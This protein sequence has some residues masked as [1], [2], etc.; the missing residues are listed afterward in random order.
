MTPTAM[1]ALGVLGVFLGLALALSI[2]G[3][4]TAERQAVGRSLAAI[5]AIQS[6]P[7]SMRRELD[8]PFIDRVVGPATD[9]LARFARRF[10]PA[11][12]ADRIRRRLD[13]AGNPPGWD[14]DRILAFRSLG[15]FSGAAIVAAIALIL[16][17]PLPQLIVL[18]IVAPLVGWFMPS[19]LLY[20]S[21]QKRSAQ[22]RRELPDALD[23]LTISVEAG[24]AFNA[25]LAEVARKTQ[26][27]VAEEFFR[28]LQE[29]QIGRGRSDAMRGLGER[30]DV[31]ELRGF[32]GAMVQADAFGIPISNVL[33][34]QSREMRV[35][36][37]QH[38]EEIAQRVPV[39][40]LFPLVFFIL[41]SLFIVILGPAVVQIYRNVLQGGL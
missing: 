4:L 3:G 31:P 5:Q 11:D 34:V 39:K 2:V 33:R 19:L 20:N 41:P 8:R 40:I 28:V 25:A 36:R 9:R 37:R 30:T 35:K 6:A 16:G 38:A 32:V 14:V 23:L 18:A 1:L 10:S 29:M 17:A 24:L 7:R 12:V 26:G 27:P 13:L 22:I 15:L 21:G